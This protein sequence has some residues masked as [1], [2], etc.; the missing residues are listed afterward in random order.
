MMRCVAY[1]IHMRYDLGYAYKVLVRKPG[2]KS[3]LGRP[4]PRW[5]DDDDDDVSGGGGA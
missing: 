3:L 2:E 1:V 5:D 4:R